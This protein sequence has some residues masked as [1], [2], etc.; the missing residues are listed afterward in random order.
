MVH[1]QGLSQ[2]RSRPVRRVAGFTLIEGLLAATVLAVAA[3]GLSVPFAVAAGHQRADVVRTTSVSLAHQMMERLLNMTYDD[4]LAMNGQTDVGASMRNANN[5][6]VN[7]NSL[8]GF[9]RTVAAE[10]V[11]LPLPGQPLEQAATLLRVVVVVQHRN[12]EY[13]RVTRLF[14]R[15]GG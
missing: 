15:V 13:A 11:V 2:G 14:G 9:T 4:V 6:A 7:D 3:A 1:T 12:T 5:A 10:E 8:V